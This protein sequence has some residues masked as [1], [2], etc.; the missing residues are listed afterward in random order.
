MQAPMSVTRAVIKSFYFS[1]FSCCKGKIWPAAGF[2]LY[3]FWCFQTAESLSPH[4]EASSCAGYDSIE[5]SVCIIMWSFWCSSIDNA[6]VI[7]S[8]E[9]L[10]P[11]QMTFYE[12]RISCCEPED[13][14]FIKAVRLKWETFNSYCYFLLWPLF[15]IQSNATSKCLFFIFFLPD[16]VHFVPGLTIL[17]I[18]RCLCAAQHQKKVFF[19][20]HKGILSH[21]FELDVLHNGHLK[22]YKLVIRGYTDRFYEFKVIN[23]QWEFYVALRT[24]DLPQ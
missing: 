4:R 11:F 3:F 17:M 8:V 19:H 18:I 14:Q 23:G 7:D 13:L 15:Y 22:L 5:T 16:L 21:I 20:I 9:V 2:T 12:R 1:S 6:L 24:L 10:S